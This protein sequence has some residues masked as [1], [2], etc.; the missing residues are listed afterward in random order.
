MA[1][2][3]IDLIEKKKCFQRESFL[4]IYIDEWIKQG[5]EVVC[6]LSQILQKINFVFKT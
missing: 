4:Y 6:P 3:L 1:A 2:M 5:N